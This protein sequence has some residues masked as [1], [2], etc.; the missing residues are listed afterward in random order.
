MKTYEITELKM[1]NNEKSESERKT[2][3]IIEPELIII[4]ITE[5]ER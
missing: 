3:K 1:K 5:Q 4:E 2:N